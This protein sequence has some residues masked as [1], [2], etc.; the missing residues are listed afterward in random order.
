MCTWHTTIFCSVPSPSWHMKDIP[1]Q[2]L[3]DALGL[4]WATQ[5]QP[6]RSPVRLFLCHGVIRVI[7]LPPPGNL[8]AW[9]PRILFSA[10]LK[11]TRFPSS[12]RIWKC[13]WVGSPGHKI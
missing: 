4:L 13:W 2:L 3:Q 11:E 8:S 5:Q 6:L 9:A 1:G 7:E 12:T 10:R